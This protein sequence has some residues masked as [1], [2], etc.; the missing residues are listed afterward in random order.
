[1]EPREPRVDLDPRVTLVSPEHQ[2]NLVEQLA[3]APSLVPRVPQD[4]LVFPEAMGNPAGLEVPASLV[5]KVSVEATVSPVLV[6]RR[7][8]VVTQVHRD[9][10]AESR[11][12]DVQAHLA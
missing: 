10:L 3:L 4:P 9:H 11:H 5:L 6:G 2:V 7:E 12:L 1:M 8:S